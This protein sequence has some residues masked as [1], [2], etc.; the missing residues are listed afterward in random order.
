[1]GL[2]ELPRDQRMQWA[3]YEIRPGD[4]LGAIAR[5]HRTTPQV[6][7][8]INKLNG[9]TIIAGRTLLIPGPS[10][11]KGDYS[12][13]EDSRLAANQSRERKGRQR[14]NYTVQSGDTLWEISR[15]YSVG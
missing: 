9:N 6:L 1:T 7:R 11:G 3:R 15:R 4:N 5:K 12:L 14:V 8:S 13:S 10:S 2:A